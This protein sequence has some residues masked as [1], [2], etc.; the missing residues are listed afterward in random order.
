LTA[1]SISQRLLDAKRIVTGEAD[2]SVRVTSRVLRYLFELRVH[3]HP[4]VAIR[5]HLALRDENFFHAGFVHFG[6]HGV[7]TV[8]LRQAADGFFHAANETTFFASFQR[9]I[10]S[11]V[12]T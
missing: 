12:A 3:I 9:L 5:P 8:E 6:E 2:E 1:R 11:G 7:E 10:N 4:L